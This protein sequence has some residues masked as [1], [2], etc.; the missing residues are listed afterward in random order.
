M[1]FL[2]A[3]RLFW[4]CKLLGGRF[5]FGK[6]TA[7]GSSF[8]KSFCMIHADRFV[9]GVCCFRLHPFRAGNNLNT[10]ERW[11]GGTYHR[12]RCFATTI[13]TLSR[14]QILLYCSK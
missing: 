11:L 2:A 7:R 3:P 6:R 10:N 5:F 9:S 8:V 14:L 13:H 12:A 4:A 1:S